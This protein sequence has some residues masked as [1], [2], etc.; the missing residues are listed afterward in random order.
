MTGR[1]GTRQRALIEYIRENPGC[2]AGEAAKA[3]C[4]RAQEYR[5][6][7]VILDLEKR[8]LIGSSGSLTKHGG[9]GLMVTEFDSAR[10]QLA[11]MARAAERAR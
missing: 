2:S 10:E 11:A 4:G 3:A 5:G 7:L 8:G 6:R 1:I 9:R